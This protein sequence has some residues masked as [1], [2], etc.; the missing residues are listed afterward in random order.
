M[1]EQSL[2]RKGKGA[3]KSHLYEMFVAAFLLMI[4]LVFYLNPVALNSL[5]FI[6]FDSYQRFAPAPTPDLSP[7]LV[8]AIDE[9]SV[10]QQGQ[11]PWP[12]TAMARLTE[13]LGAAG[14]RAIVF[15]IMFSEPDRTS[16]EQMLA[17]L[18]PDQRARIERDVADWP[19]HDDLFERAIE[20]YPV[21]LAA[22]LHGTRTA[23]QFPHKAGIVV[24]GDDP[25]RFLAGFSGF[26]GNLPALTDAASGVGSIN[27][28]PDRDQVVR[29]IPV[30]F[31]QGQ[32]IVPSLA[33]EA[34]RVAEGEDTY[35]VR[36]SNAHGARAFGQHAGVNQVRVGRHAIPTDPQAAV[37]IRFRRA[38]P[39]AYV[40]AASILGSEF[41]PALIRD[42]IVLIGATA[43]GLMDLRATPLDAAAPGVEVHQ[44]ALEQMLAAR[45]LTRSDVA[46]GLEIV[47]AVAAVIL[48]A[49][50]APRLSA[51]VG[52]FLGGAIV[53]LIWGGSV[54]AYLSWGQLFDP[55]FPSACAF[56]FGAGSAFYLYRRTELQQAEIRRA[57]NQYVSPSVVKQ[58][59]AQP[60]RLELG[61][62]VR[63]LTLLFCDVRN[64]TT[65]SERLDAQELTTFINE[66]LTPLTDI[67]IERRGTIDKYMGDAIMAFWN[68]PLDDPE[69][70]RRACEAALQMI[71][72]LADLNV[73]WRAAADGARKPFAPVML[74]IGV[75]SGECCVGNLGS[76]R[77]FDYS[78]IG[79]NV[80]ITSRLENLTKRYALPLIVGEDTAR[81]LPDLPF[82]E[83]DLVRVK[84]RAA[85]VRIFTLLP[86]LG[87]DEADWAPLK[88]EHEA[89]L[90]AFRG[91]DST[92]ARGLLDG[93]K[94]RDV[95]DLRGV[96][97]AFEKRM[98]KLEN[99][100]GEA[101]DGVYETAEPT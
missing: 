28:R 34:L 71:R 79:D 88:T 52:A 95:E 85:P 82:L 75:N 3:R 65:I 78:A 97:A 68:A 59:V 63:D 31:R 84:G 54:L 30:L 21:V 32:T 15:D 58:L 36:S 61:G 66:L 42:R 92:G 73:Q 89:F 47:I 24:A 55:V 40:S 93:L 14:A 70:A 19:T 27:W 72:A 45:Y 25:A 37:W 46:T 26:T 22:T 23:D 91:G 86:A 29:R 41:D 62:E 38:D 94:Q 43:P 56:L 8:V 87:L 96:Y 67:I 12:R 18:E 4:A 100:L 17:W 48:L 90:A 77:R 11:W 69:H 7:V 6:V 80:N 64:F 57:F 81:R 16:P 9:Q 74:G 76:T 98:E 5:R 10:A 49:F 33:L 50:A 39:G 35:L 1:S 20:R 60:D 51:G 13:R 2:R 83:V 44:Q 53:L 99:R 101:W